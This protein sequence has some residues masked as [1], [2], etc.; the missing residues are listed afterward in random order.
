MAPKKASSTSLQRESAIPNSGGEGGGATTEV[1]LH[2]S[3][4]LVELDVGAV[5]LEEALVAL[6]DEVVAGE[7]GE[8]PLCV[9][10]PAL[11][12]CTR[13]KMRI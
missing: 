9:H 6:L 7:V 13:M 1:L 12:I 4:C 8:S 3:L 5:V 10:T 2:G 11:S